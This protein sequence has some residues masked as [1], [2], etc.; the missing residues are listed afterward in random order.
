MDFNFKKYQILKLQKY[1][2]NKG[3]FFF[4]HCNK[5]NLSQW[6]HI[7]QNLTKLEL[8]Y[9]KP[10]NKVLNKILKNSIY[11]NFSFIVNGFVLFV[12][13]SNDNKELNLQQIQKS[14][15]ANFLLTGVKLNNKV[16]STTQVKQMKTLSYKQN[17]FVLHNTLDRYLKNSYALTGTKKK[18]KSK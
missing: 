12:S 7:E 1:F 3:L 11:K 18:I 6:T 15:A 17:M 8:N 9:Y 5:L 16:Y 14:L 10:L 4:V 2:K 13:S